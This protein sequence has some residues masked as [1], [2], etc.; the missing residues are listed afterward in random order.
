M[1][2]TERLLESVKPDEP[3]GPNLEYDAAFTELERIA[4]GRAEQ[5]IGTTVTEAEE[6]NWKEVAE[7]GAKLLESTKDLRVGVHLAKALL[8]TGG[9]AGARDGLAILAGMVQKYWD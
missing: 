6:P 2:A 1:I 5:Q 7:K 3:C 8:R 9:F 4:K